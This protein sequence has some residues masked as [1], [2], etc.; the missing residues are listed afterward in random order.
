MAVYGYMRISTEDQRDDL[1]RDA[2][3]RAGVP[4]EQ[5]YMDTVS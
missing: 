3:V 2:L 5:I 4:E 1:Q